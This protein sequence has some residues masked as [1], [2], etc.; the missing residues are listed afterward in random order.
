M[1]SVWGDGGP[2]P[3]RHHQIVV[4]EL[5]VRVVHRLVVAV[6]HGIV[7]HAMCLGIQSGGHGEVVD[8]RLR[9]ERAA[10][11]RRR[12][13]RVPELGHVRRH[14]GLDIIG[15]ETVERYDHRHRVSLDGGRRHRHCEDCDQALRG[16]SDCPPAHGGRRKKIVHQRRCGW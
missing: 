10:H 12:G 7:E 1:Y 11:V 15:T 2:Y 6:E 13:G 9:G 8:E 16:H 5:L 4:M 14:V 3:D